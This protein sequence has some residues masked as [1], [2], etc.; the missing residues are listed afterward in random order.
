MW[1]AIFPDK[2]QPSCSI[3]EAKAAA[4]IRSAILLFPKHQNPE[5]HKSS[6]GHDES[7]FQ[8]FGIDFGKFGY[9][10]TKIKIFPRNAE[11]FRFFNGLEDIPV[12]VS[13]R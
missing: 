11:Q 12:P 13:D 2:K 9:V 6:F 4:D 5:I 7:E 8:N 10:S 3:P 1:K